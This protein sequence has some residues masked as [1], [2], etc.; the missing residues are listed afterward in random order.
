MGLRN[1]N[2][3][4]PDGFQN[5]IMTL[6]NLPNLK[7]AN[8]YHGPLAPDNVHLEH[9][10]KQFPRLE[11][12][13]LDFAAP[14]GS[15]TTITP[16]GLAKLQQ[17]PLTVLNIENAGNFDSEHLKAIAGIKTLQS[18]LVDARR[19]PA[20][21]ARAITVFRE[22]RPKVDVVIAGPDAK[23]PPREKR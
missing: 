15:Q 12:L 19:R 16:A 3:E 18:L 11:Y 17:L 2:K 21:S 20:P 1:L 23:G 5:A 8:W 4:T 14:R 9:I 7:R 22:L 10:V 6:N 13:R